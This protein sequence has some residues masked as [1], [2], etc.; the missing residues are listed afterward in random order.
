MKKIQLL[1]LFLASIGI[2]YGQKMF[3]GC[4][5]L[6]HYDQSKLLNIALPM[7]GIGTGTVSLGGRGELKA[8]QIM[9]RPGMNYSTVTPGN[10]APFFSIYVKPED[11]KAITKALIG[12]LHPS[13]YQHYEGRPVNNHGMPRFSSAS[14]DASY[15]F[16]Q[17]NLKDNQIPVSVKIIGFN[18]FIPGNA[19][20]SSIP[21]AIL[22]YEVTNSTSTAVEVAVCGTMR[23]FIG[24]DGSS[25]R[26]DWKG[27]I[28]PTGAKK[29]LNNLF[30]S[31]EF[32]L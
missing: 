14:F 21:M 3:N 29:N 2:V 11:K 27:D 28:I 4:P 9:N 26:K 25:F 23:N 5:I 16:G 10:N 12:P 19:D 32:D 7:G 1:I 22:K 20:A 30:I 15:P 13:E 8:W 6:K 18:P 24:Q 31:L 17:V